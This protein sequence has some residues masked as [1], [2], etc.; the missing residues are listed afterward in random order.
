MG[1]LAT[2]VYRKVKNEAGEYETVLVQ[3]L[4]DE[5]TSYARTFEQHEGHLLKAAIG[6]KSGTLCPRY[7]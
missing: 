4:P 1:V 7:K 3:L 2:E 6:I 5:R